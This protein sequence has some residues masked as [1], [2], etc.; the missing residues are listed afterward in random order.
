M[1]QGKKR[2]KHRG[3]NKNSFQ[4]INIQIVEELFTEIPVLQEN[5]L[6]SNT[7]VVCIFVTR[8]EVQWPIHKKM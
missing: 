6:S 2:K 1:N 4:S 3:K 8:A 5:Y 7:Q